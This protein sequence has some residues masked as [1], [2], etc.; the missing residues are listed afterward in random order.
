MGIDGVLVVEHGH[1]VGRYPY[2]NHKNEKQPDFIQKVKASSTALWNLTTCLHFAASMV[3][4]ATKNVPKR[5]GASRCNGPRA[6]QLLSGPLRASF[7]L[8][9]YVLDKFVA[10][11]ISSLREN[12]AQDISH[13]QDLASSWLRTF[14]L[15]SM[16]KFPF[17]EHRRQYIFYLLRR[18]EGAI[19]GRDDIW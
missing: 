10:P 2:F 14:V 5:Y 15:V 11:G 16:L 3:T 13:I 17:E 19:K 1:F 4:S 9:N 18:A 8:S 12:R 6:G 7:M